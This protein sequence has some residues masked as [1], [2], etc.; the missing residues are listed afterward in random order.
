[1]FFGGCMNYSASM[2]NVTS[3]GTDNIGSTVK[4]DLGSL[5]DRVN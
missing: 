2:I 3:I 4:G 5:V 1:M